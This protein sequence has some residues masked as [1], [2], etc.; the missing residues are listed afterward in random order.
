MKKI[1][2][3]EK[4]LKAIINESVKDEIYFDTFSAAVQKAREHTEAKGYEI[5][6]DDW[7]TEVSVGNGRPKEGHTTRMT[8]GLLRNGKPQKKALQIQ[9]FNRGNELRNNYE[10]NFYIF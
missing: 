9:V 10:L 2:V 4:Q 3:T 6:E 7:W 8:I 5:N 1:I